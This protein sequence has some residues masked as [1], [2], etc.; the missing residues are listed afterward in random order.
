MELLL[1]NWEL[2]LTVAT[3]AASIFFGLRLKVL[4]D[5]VK[6]GVEAFQV[7]QEIKNDGKITAQEQEE[8]DK[9]LGEF[10]DKLKEAISLF[11]K[12]K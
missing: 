5:L 2:I 1:D 12:K 11:K 8:L 10:F 4:R 6:E 7:Y 9:E 3:T